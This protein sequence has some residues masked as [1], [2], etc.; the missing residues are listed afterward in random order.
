M[1]K[2]L[3]TKELLVHSAL[4]LIQVMSFD[5]MTVQTIV[6]N[7]GVARKT[8]YNHFEDKFDLFRFIYEKSVI[9]YFFSI[10]PEYTWLQALTDSL[11]VLERYFPPA[12]GLEN[13]ELVDVFPLKLMEAIFALL[14]SHG[15]AFDGELVYMVRYTAY[16]YF[17][18]VNRW[19]KSGHEQSPEELAHFLLHCL[20]LRLSEILERINVLK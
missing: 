3:S 11:T 14:E 20:P 19:H 18:S 15:V 6:E 16:A 8:F 13:K 5:E 12:Q 1:S 10:S 17:N 9:D 2:K 4:E 7:C